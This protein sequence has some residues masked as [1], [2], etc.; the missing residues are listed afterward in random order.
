[1]KNRPL[2]ERLGFAAE[3]LRTGWLRERSFRTQSIAALAALLLLILVRPP[4]FWW[5]LVAVVAA[6]VLALE[7]LNSAVEGVIDLLHPGLH[8]EIRAIK[9]MIAGA[10]LIVS[11]AALVVGVSLVVA[12]L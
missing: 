8:P 5:A 1:V 4:A 11:L 6:M 12:V 7:L 3:G 10:V 2:H 9:D